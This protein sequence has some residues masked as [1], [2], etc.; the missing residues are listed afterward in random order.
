MLYLPSRRRGSLK[1]PAPLRGAG[2]ESDERVAGKFE[3]VRRVRHSL[4][5]RGRRRACLPRDMRGSLRVP[6]AERRAGRVCRE[7]S[8]EV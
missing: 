1:V 6:A 7:G 4:M 2:G 3:G 8:G 5:R